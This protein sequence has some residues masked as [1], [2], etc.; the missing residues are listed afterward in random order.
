MIGAIT[1]YLSFDDEIIVVF[2]VLTFISILTAKIS[3]E[4][5]TSLNAITE[6]TYEIV[7][8]IMQLKRF[9]MGR[10]RAMIVF[11]KHYRY[12]ILCQQVSEFRKIQK[13]ID[14]KVNLYNKIFKKF[15]KNDLNILIG[16]QINLLKSVT[17][18]F[19]NSNFVSFVVNNP[20][21]TNNAIKNSVKDGVS[22]ELSN[23]IAALLKDNKYTNTAFNSSTKEP[24]K[25][26]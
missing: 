4:I 5:W 19:I 15:L 16:E 25:S 20:K 24:N 13:Y 18:F 23:D 12:A 10:S 21:F 14:F 17:K 7:Y 11:L 6:E 3:S 22:S 1:G 8:D 2:C 9:V 26:F